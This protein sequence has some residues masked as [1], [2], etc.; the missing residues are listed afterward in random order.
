MDIDS[1]F[2]LGDRKDRTPQ[3]HSI[4]ISGLHAD[5]DEDLPKLSISRAKKHTLAI[6]DGKADDSDDAYASLPELLNASDSSAD[7]V[8]DSDSESDEDP[9]D[10][11]GSGYNTED[12]DELRD[13]LREAM[14]IAHESGFLDPTN[15][16]PDPGAYGE[17]RKSN[18][19]L[20]LLGSLRGMSLSA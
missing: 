2:Q 11:D 3:W 17:E 10:L 1:L 20:K 18:P 7:H 6:T 9:E 5:S 8:I 13:L 16:T 12:E 19:F 15:S 14:D 4:Y